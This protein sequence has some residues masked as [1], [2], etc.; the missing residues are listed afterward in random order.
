MEPGELEIKKAFEETTTKNVRTVIAY[1]NETRAL[2]RKL[3]EQIKNQQNAIIVI[4]QTTNR[5]QQQ[6][7]TVQAQLYAKGDNNGSNN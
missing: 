6:L 2:I 1:S 7:A 5:L 4:N 3:E